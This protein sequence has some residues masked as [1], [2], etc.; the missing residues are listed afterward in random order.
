MDCQVNNVTKMPGP[1]G[2][3]G[4]NGSQGLPGAQG[5]VGPPGSRGA[6]NFS[7]CR[8]LKADSGGTSAGP[9][10]ATSI[11]VSERIVSS[12]HNTELTTLLIG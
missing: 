6:G 8:Y 3:R 10:A 7:Q 5:P 4:Y 9:L 11:S 2:P 12:G 1:A